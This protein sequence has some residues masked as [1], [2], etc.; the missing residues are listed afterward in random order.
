MLDKVME[1]EFKKTMEVFDE[2][3]VK[4]KKD[5]MLSLLED[6]DREELQYNSLRNIQSNLQEQLKTSDMRKNKSNV[7]NRTGF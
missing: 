1:E 6:Q 5:Q 2:Y 4:K 3:V 7:F